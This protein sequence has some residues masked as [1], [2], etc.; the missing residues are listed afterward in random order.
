LAGTL[1]G[2]LALGLISNFYARFWKPHITLTALIPGKHQQQPKQ[3]VHHSHLLSL[4][5]S[6]SLSGIGILMMVPGALGVR[7]LSTISLGDPVA[8]FS[9]VVLMFLVALQLSV[10]MILSNTFLPVR[11]YNVEWLE[12]CNTIRKLGFR[13]AIIGVGVFSTH[14]ELLEDLLERD[15][16]A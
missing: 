7:G 5:L 1:L 12:V 2:G 11:G 6:L 16:T 13:G 10:A 15:A 8:G 9:F 14:T 4:S 3:V